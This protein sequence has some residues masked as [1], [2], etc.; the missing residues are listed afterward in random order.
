MRFGGELLLLVAEADA[1]TGEVVAAAA[2]VVGVEVVEEGEEDE[3]EGEGSSFDLNL[4]FAA[5]I[6]DACVASVP[7][8]EFVGLS[9][10]SCE[11]DIERICALNPS[12]KT[13]SRRFG[14]L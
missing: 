11:C 1:G 5:W 4:F 9:S 10:K 2:V 3:A 7:N 6:V 13:L 12:L 14:C 8:F